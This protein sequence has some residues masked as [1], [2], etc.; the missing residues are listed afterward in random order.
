ML[1][2]AKTCVKEVVYKM[3]FCVSTVIHTYTICKLH[4]IVLMYKL[5]NVSE[6]NSTLKQDI[7]YT[8]STVQTRF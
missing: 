1:V 5:M 8:F 7:N 3:Y 4:S 6:I 2:F